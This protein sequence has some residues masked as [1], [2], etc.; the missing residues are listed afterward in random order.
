MKVSNDTARLRA[1]AIVA[2]T[3]LAAASAI[4]EDSWTLGGTVASQ[5]YAAYSGPAGFD[6]SKLYYGSS[7]SLGLELEAKGD[8]ARVYAS[9]EAALLSGVA[10]EVAWAVAASPYARPDELLLP[11]SPTGSGDATALAA[12]LRALYLKLELGPASLT[13]GRQVVNYGRGALWSPTDIFTELDLTGLSPVR[14]GSD[15]LRLGLPFGDTAGL[16]LVAAPKLAFSDGNYALRVRDLVG[17]VDGALI[18]ARDGERSG[19]VVGADFKADLELG[20]YGE[21]SYEL[22]DSGA[23]GILRAAGGTDYSIGDFIL[24]AEYYYNGGGS[25]AD[26]L[27]PG[28]HNVYGSLTWKA[29]ELLVVS[30]TL[31]WDAS[32]GAGTGTLIASY[33]ATQSATLGAFLQASYGQSNYGLAFGLA[34]ESWSY[35]VGLSLSVKF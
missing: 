25:A 3:L 8:R 18:A 15:A 33:N 32:D 6:A 1:T 17:G 2:A 28:S 30:G 24:A 35:E 9:V 4:A 19:T 20:L 27:F 16:D 23:K 22:F 29:S 10:A 26:P 31:V 34:S 13:A 14:L 7:S 5:P 21:A 11:A 12:R